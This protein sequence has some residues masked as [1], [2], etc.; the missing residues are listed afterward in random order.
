MFKTTHVFHKFLIWY[1]KNLF[2]IL[3]WR[4]AGIYH[5]Q[6]KTQIVVG[7]VFARSKK[8]CLFDTGL[9]SDARHFGKL[10]KTQTQQQKLLMKGIMCVFAKLSRCRFYRAH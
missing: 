8:L 2:I 7:D 9:S 3:I 5:L 6:N 4:Q 1:A 10:E